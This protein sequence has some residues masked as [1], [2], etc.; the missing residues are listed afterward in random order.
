MQF[1]LKNSE[2]MLHHN[3]PILRNGKTVGHLTSGSY[4]HALG[5]AVGLGYV[6]CE[7]NQG[8][9]DILKDHFEIEVEGTIEQVSVSLIPM[10]DPQNKKIRT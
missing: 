9:E 5:G 6:D 4:G 10:F 8:D 1:L 3:E 7:P 2:A